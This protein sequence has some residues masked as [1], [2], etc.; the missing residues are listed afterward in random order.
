ME[1]E[2]RIET[3]D[4]KMRTFVARPDGDG[5]YPVAVIYMDAPGY[6]DALKEIARRYARS[7]YYT[8]LPDLYHPHG[9]VTFDLPELFRDPRG[10]SASG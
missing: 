8:V 3:Q 9:D 5:P 2:I 7:G 6:R 10:P 4:G 1:T